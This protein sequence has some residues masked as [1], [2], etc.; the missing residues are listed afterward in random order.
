[1]DSAPR[2][3]HQPSSSMTSRGL[4]VRLCTLHPADRTRPPDDRPQPQ[5]RRRSHPRLPPPADHAP[6]A[7]LASHML[8]SKHMLARKH[9]I[10]GSIHEYR[11]TPTIPRPVHRIAPRLHTGAPRHSTGAHTPTTGAHA[12]TT[13]THKTTADRRRQHPPTRQHCR[14]ARTPHYRPRNRQWINS[15]S[16]SL[17]EAAA[18]ARW[19]KPKRKQAQNSSSMKPPQPAPHLLQLKLHS[20]KRRV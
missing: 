16:R 11:R 8:A 15:P 20:S 7:H 14:S 17:D 18:L 6:G 3:I 9:K 1:M 12:P 4:T 19:G 5:R 13:G 2:P 10:N